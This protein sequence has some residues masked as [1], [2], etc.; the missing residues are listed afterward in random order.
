MVNIKKGLG[1]FLS[2]TSLSE[3][4][5]GWQNKKVGSASPKLWKR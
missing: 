4:K 1:W 2:F 5:E 3:K